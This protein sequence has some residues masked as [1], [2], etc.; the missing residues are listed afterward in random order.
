MLQL[1]S[2][3]RFSPDS[4]IGQHAR[5]CL[6]EPIDT[7]Q[8]VSILLNRSRYQDVAIIGHGPEATLR[9]GETLSH[10]H[11]CVLSEL[12]QFRV[13]C[14]HR[15]GRLG[16]ICD[17]PSPHATSEMSAA[18]VSTEYAPHSRADGANTGNCPA[19]ILFNPLH[20]RPF[21]AQRTVTS[22]RVCAVVG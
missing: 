1:R 14:A 11:A 8:V 18:G 10:W 2:N 21:F 17:Y 16:V 15:R 6:T 22:L 19:V 5:A 3:R 9:A 13:L 7:E 12:E 20:S 4:G